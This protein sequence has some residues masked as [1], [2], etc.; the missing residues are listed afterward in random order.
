MYMIGTNVFVD[1]L[2]GKSPTALSMLQK[3][4]A[5]LFKVPSVVKAELL[6]GAC[7]AQ[8]RGEELRK[9]EELL[10]PFE[11]VPFDDACAFKYAQ[12]RTFL[13]SKGSGIGAN[14]Y[15][16]AAT[17][18][19]YSAVLVTNNAKEFGRIPGLI[20]EEWADIDFE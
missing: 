17:T 10:M 14:D 1:F 11:I 18:L 16:I 5:S 15:L 6:L 4:D 2:R 20:I 7:K 8:I 19:A 12:I 13:E 3:S 9:V